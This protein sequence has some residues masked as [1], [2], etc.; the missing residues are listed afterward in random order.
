MVA[1]T[2]PTLGRSCLSPGK[3]VWLLS[4]GSL[5]GTA[6]RLVERT[7]PCAERVAATHHDRLQTTWDKR[8]SADNDMTI[9][10]YL[11]RKP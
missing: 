1:A 4:G 3:S 10:G 6:P 2:P 7:S 9:H 8:H 5:R 11:Q